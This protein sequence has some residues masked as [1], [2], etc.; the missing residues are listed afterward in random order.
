MVSIDAEQIRKALKN[1]VDNALKFSR[2][3]S[4]PVSITLTYEAT[5]AAITIQDH[6]IGIPPEELDFIFEP[7]YRVDKSRSPQ[8]AGY[9]LGLSLAK[10]IIEAHG[11][12]IRIHSTPDKGT[13]V[14]IVLPL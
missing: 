14:E 7:F 11:G 8:T 2:P 3:D 6:G 9:G 10:T 1:I 4:E 5:H 13:G 12:S